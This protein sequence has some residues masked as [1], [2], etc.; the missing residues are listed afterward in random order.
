MTTWP[1]SRE[2]IFNIVLATTGGGLVREVYRE[3]VR[4]SPL[5]KEEKSERL[6]G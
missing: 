5:G 4:Q 1:S 3:L 6:F 2:Q